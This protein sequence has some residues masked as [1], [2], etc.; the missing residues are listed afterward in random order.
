MWSSAN[1]NEK[2]WYFCFCSP[3]PCVFNWLCIWTICCHVLPKWIW[4]DCALQNQI[5]CWWLHATFRN[6]WNYFVSMQ[7]MC[8]TVSI[9]MSNNKYIFTGM[10]RQ[11]YIYVY[12]CYI[13]VFY[14]HF[15]FSQNILCFTNVYIWFSPD[16][17]CFCFFHISYKFWTYTDNLILSS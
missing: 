16:L 17:C 15:T 12:H 14:Y 1:N 6:V 10:T 5:I 7:T 13:F 3:P 2:K 9:A 4:H 8:V 11:V